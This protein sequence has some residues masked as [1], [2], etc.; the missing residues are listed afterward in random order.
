MSS[1]QAAL[2]FTDALCDVDAEAVTAITCL[3]AYVVGRK[4]A[5]ILTKLGFEVK[6]A[7]NAEELVPV[8]QSCAAA[9]LAKP[10]I[11]L[12]GD[13]RLDTIPFALHRMAV[14]FQE[15]R[16][17]CT[18]AAPAAA[19]AEPIR[20]AL[21]HSCSSAPRIAA[22]VVF[23]PSGIDAVL[24]KA[25]SAAADAT[26]TALHASAAASVTPAASTSIGSGGA[27]DTLA[28]TSG[29]GGDESHCADRALLRAVFERSRCGS[30]GHAAAGEADVAACTAPAG[31]AGSGLN[32]DGSAL[33]ATAEFYSHSAAAARGGER[34]ALLEEDSSLLAPWS[35]RLVA[36]G[37]T[38]A[39][40][41]AA[42]GF[43]PAAVCASPDAVGVE[44]ALRTL[45]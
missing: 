1:Q 28:V 33:A 26:S 7:S 2:A 37:K 31:G 11:F 23:S 39:A 32:H 34:L 30:S 8:L 10:L 43:P 29:G 12:V 19:I 14:P 16:V 41:L 36:I 15:L 17:Y 20:A 9:H 4:S 22:L 40:A 45:V 18:E 24:G 25:E 3:P 38:T 21:V 42:R 13:K 5:D 27:T 6:C 44:A 35:I